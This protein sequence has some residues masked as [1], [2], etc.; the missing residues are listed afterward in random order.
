[1]ASGCCAGSAGSAA[2]DARRNGRWPRSGT[3]RP[4]EIR[5]SGQ[6]GPGGVIDY[7]LARIGV[8]SEY[9]KGRLARH[10]VCDAHPELQRAAAAASEPTSQECPTCEAD[11]TVLVTYASRDRSP[12]SGRCLPAPRVPTPLTQDS[13]PP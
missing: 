10:E 9:R 13:T 11:N 1:M 2:R 8:V 12:T 4:D 5:G 3:F 6:Q 7:R